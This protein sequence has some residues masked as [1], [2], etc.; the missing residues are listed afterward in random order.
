MKMKI[1]YFRMKG[2][3][4]ILQ[5]MGLDEIVIPFADMKSRIVLIQGINGSGKSIIFNIKKPPKIVY[6]IL[7]GYIHLFYKFIHIICTNSF[8]II[9]GIWNSSHNDIFHN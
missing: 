5:G 2:Y 9:I 1:L 3:I 7:K 4:N 6:S 8:Y